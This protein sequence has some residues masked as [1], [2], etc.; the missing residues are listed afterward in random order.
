MT[1][2]QSST[3]ELTVLEPRT[4]AH[5]ALPPLSFSG[6]ENENFRHFRRDLE[7]YV[8]INS[9]E[10]N[11]R[12]V[13]VLQAVLRGPALAYFERVIKPRYRVDTP[14]STDISFQVSYYEALEDLQ[15]HYVTEYDILRFRNRFDTSTQRDNESPRSF[16]GRLREL[17]FESDID[18]E[19][20]IKSRFKSGLLPEIKQHCILLQAI[21]H[22][23]VFNAA[24]G[25]W[26]AQRI[27]NEFRS[28]QQ[29]Q[30]QHEQTMFTSLGAPYDNYY[31]HPY[32]EPEPYQPQA[33]RRARPQVRFSEFDPTSDPA[34]EQ[35]P[36]RRNEPRFRESNQGQAP[37]G[38]G[39]RYQGQR[40][41]DARNQGPWNH[42]GR[43]NDNWRT[44]NWRNDHW[45]NDNHPTN[46][47]QQGQPPSRFQ[48]DTRR[49]HQ[50]EP[51]RQTPQRSQEEP[52][53]SYPDE[54]R[55][56]PYQDNQRQAQNQEGTSQ[57]REPRTQ[58]QE[59]FAHLEYY[60]ESQQEYYEYSDQCEYQEQNYR[61]PYEVEYFD[62]NDDDDNQAQHQEW[63]STHQS[64]N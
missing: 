23:Q 12:R 28:Y 1:T 63:L 18:D 7:S 46:N 5:S 37:R 55:R 27:S 52:H 57:S 62:P 2:N 21:T 11:Y 26:E 42:Q 16:L 45:R 41:Q 29:R 30:R 58:P 10:S 64:K 39:Q 38:Q 53:R 3:G 13:C 15:D 8:L 24:E 40:S 60:P 59:N 17:A 25:F 51:R 50:G 56:P 47:R 54:Q 32:Q 33:F 22:E 31:R 44:N 20:L 48:D 49:P 14:D 6:L 35:Y 61:Y 19:A 36:Q 9:I 4:I 34:Q 43:R